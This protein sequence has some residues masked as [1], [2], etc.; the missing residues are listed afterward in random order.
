MTKEEIKDMSNSILISTLDDIVQF[1]LLQLSNSE[2]LKL[3]E[4]HKKYNQLMNEIRR[5]LEKI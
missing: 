4:E 5:R 3:L 1:D 2:W